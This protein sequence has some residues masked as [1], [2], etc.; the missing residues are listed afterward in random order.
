MRARQSAAATVA[1]ACAN[2]RQWLVATVDAAWWRVARA[3]GFTLTGCCFYHFNAPFVVPLYE[4]LEFLS[5]KGI[6]QSVFNS[7]NT[8][9][10]FGPQW[11]N[12][13]QINEPIFRELA[14]KFFASFGFDATPCRESKDVATLSGLRNAETINATHFTHMF[15][16]TIGDGD[17]HEGECLL[18]TRERLGGRVEVMKRKGDGRVWET[19]EFGGS[20]DNYR[21]MSPRLYLMRRSLEVLR[22]FHWMILGGRFNQLSHVSSPLLSKPGEY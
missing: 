15:W 13:F 19:K 11:A 5:N 1:A 3:G 9:P 6:A 21:N 2:V 20:A 10:F 12:L 7:I 8:D 16:T 4:I 17:L 22:K 14:R 18:P